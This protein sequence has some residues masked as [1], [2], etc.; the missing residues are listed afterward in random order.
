VQLY[1]RDV[2][3]SVVVPY[4]LLKGFK[5]ITLK[6]G[7]TKKVS[8]TLKPQ[9]LAFTNIDNKCIAEPGEFIVYVG[10]SSR[11]KDLLTGNFIYSL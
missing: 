11:N 5:R 10:S 6:A 9:N 4:K 7:Q 2:I 8:L 1:V 3:S